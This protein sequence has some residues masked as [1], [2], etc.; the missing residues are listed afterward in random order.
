MN[1]SEIIYLALGSNLGNRSLNLVR[2]CSA[3]KK[4]IE[5][6]RVSHIYETPPW[7]VLDQPLFLNQVIE[8]KTDLSPEDLLQ[9]AK[10][11]EIDLGRVPAER[12][13]PRL[14]D[15]DLLLFGRQEIHTETLTIPHPR[16]AERAFVL[17]PLNELAPDLSIPATENKSVRELLGAVDPSGIVQYKEHHGK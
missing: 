1:N 11:I 17:V 10:K 16:L 4:F 2:A 5:I 13:G 14:I 9:Q 3:L 12:Y 8:A 6:S 7:G 15:I